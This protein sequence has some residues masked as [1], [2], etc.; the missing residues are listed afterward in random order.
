MSIQGL[1]D[2][3]RDIAILTYLFV[4]IWKTESNQLQIDIL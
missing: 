3:R 4:L 1:S 2:C